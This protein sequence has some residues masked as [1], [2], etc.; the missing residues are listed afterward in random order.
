MHLWVN[1]GP[2][3]VGCLTAQV[4]LTRARPLWERILKGDNQAIWLRR[5]GSAH[6]CLWATFQGHWCIRTKKIRHSE[7][8]PEQGN[9]LCLCLKEEK[10]KGWWPGPGGQCY[11]APCPPPSHRE[12]GSRP[13]GAA[14]ES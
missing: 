7:E 8:T 14:S 9:E 1:Q 11:R 2:F 13:T 5:G 12:R 6:V 3:Q 10:Q 4:A